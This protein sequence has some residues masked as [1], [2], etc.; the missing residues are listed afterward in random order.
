MRV[1]LVKTSSLG[2]VVHTFPALSDLMGA[3]PGI[4]VDWLVEEAYTDLPRRHPAVDRVI[5]VA[6][7]RW[8]KKP[9]AALTGEFPRFI[10]DLRATRYDLI[11]DAQGLIKSALL[12]AIARGKSVGL[13]RDSAREPLA[14]LAYDHALAAPRD[15]HAIHRTRRLF[16]RIFNYPLPETSPRY[17]LENRWQEAAQ[18]KGCLIFLHGAAWRTKLWPQR[19]WAALARLASQ[20]GYEVH[21]P[22][23]DEVERDRAKRIIAAAGVGVLMA[24]MELA[25][26]IRAVEGCA[27]VVGGDSGLVH[28]AVAFG[29]PALAIFGPTDQRLTGLQGEPVGNLSSSRSCAP[30]MLKACPYMGEEVKDPPCLIDVT[31]EQVWAGMEALVDRGG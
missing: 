18:R 22:W 2:D 7:R 15:L 29:I 10:A 6:L 11:I 21:F 1:L 26:M 20:A 27:G 31:P 25:E 16:S 5:P 12:C 9:L 23:G 19:H 13:D 3:M 14:C 17:L 28:L 8:R 4:R 24:R 30:C